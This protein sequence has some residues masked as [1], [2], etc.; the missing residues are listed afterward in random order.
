MSDKNRVQEAA[1]FLY[2]EHQARKPF[3]PIPQPYTPSSID[4]ADAVQEAFQKLLAEA[5]GP[6]AGYKIAL[7]TPVMRQMLG[8]N[9]PIAGAILAKT[10]QHSPTTVRGTDYVHLGVECE[11]AFQLTKELPAARAPYSRDT[12]ADAVG[13]AMAAF[14][15]VDDRNADFSKLAAQVLSV[16]ADNTWNAGIVL[17]AP[18]TN[19][20]TVDL[21]AVRGTMRING[22]V[23]GEG[24]GSDVMGHPLEAL[25]WLVNMFARRGKSLSPGMTVMTGSVVAVKFVNSGD[26]VRLSVD[27]L[28]EVNLHVT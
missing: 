19:W 24:R 18:V 20:R 11:I 28:G 10:I 5:Y 17:G 22:V 13:P 3:E 9:E 4:E 15:L 2:E 25:V 23:V 7:T 26:A 1:R 16:R 12:V 27:G 6:I 8:V 14:E 21:A